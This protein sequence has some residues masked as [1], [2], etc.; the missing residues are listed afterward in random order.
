MR[1]RLLILLAF[2]ILIAIS[3][4]NHRVRSTADVPRTLSPSITVFVAPF[5]QPITTGQLITGSIPEP[6]GRISLEQLASLDQQIRTLL[7]TETRHS[8]KFLTSL[9]FPH[10]LMAFH[11]SG[12]PQGLPLWIAY[13]KKQGAQLLLV[14]LVLDWHER[15]GSGA[16]VTSS[17]HVRVE[18]FLI[19][20]EKE[21][22]MGR[23]IFEEKQ[24]GLVD[25]LLTVGSFLKRGGQWV[26]AERLC[27]DGIRKAARDLGL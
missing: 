22:V 1:R 24:Q 16:G 27:T 5:T 17:A 10:T 18:F 21:L 15:E 13:G 7:S 8:Y 3:A 25:N 12:Q 9:D 26:T 11:S 23:S 6:Q 14:P 20:V 19:N 2:C 4:C